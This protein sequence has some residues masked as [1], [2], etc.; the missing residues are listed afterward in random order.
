MEAMIQFLR[1]F[2]V[3]GPIAS[4]PTSPNPAFSPPT[5]PFIGAQ[6]LVNGGRGMN[7]NGNANVN[8]VNGVNGVNM[9]MGAQSEPFVPEFVYEAM[10]LNKRFDTMRVSFALLPLC[11]NQNV[12]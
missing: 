10:R 9:T 5:T 4:A 12:R 1:E 8:G 2:Q 11:L 7:P 6:T 3:V